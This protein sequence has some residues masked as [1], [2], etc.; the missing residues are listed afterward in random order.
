MEIAVVEAIYKIFTICE[1]GEKQKQE[2]FIKK[3]REKAFTGL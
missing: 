1:I 2:Q 3:L